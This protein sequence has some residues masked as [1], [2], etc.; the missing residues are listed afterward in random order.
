MCLYIYIYLVVSRPTRGLSCRQIC[1]S[2]LHCCLL[3]KQ[4]SR[5]ESPRVGR[6]TTQILPL[7]TGRAHS[8]H[9]CPTDNRYIYI[10][11][12]VYIYIYICK[13]IIWL[14]KTTVVRVLD[15]MGAVI[16]FYSVNTPWMHWALQNCFI[17]IGMVLDRQSSEAK[18]ACKIVLN[19]GVFIARWRT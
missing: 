12:Y 13:H 4:I 17:V 15:L 14:W 6:E 19:K 5:Q 8:Q 11:M 16:Q 2:S 1:F 9:T 18:C 3:A 7:P 10:Y